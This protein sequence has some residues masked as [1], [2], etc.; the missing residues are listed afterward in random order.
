MVKKL[1]KEI[2]GH[3]TRLVIQIRSCAVATNLKNHIFLK[4]T[5]FFKYFICQNSIL[6]SQESGKKKFI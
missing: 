6:R 1:S 2:L 5:Y 3:Y 4:K